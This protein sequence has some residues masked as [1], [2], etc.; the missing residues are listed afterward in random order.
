MANK[1][2]AKDPQD[3]TVLVTG[4]A[5]FIGSHTAVELLK[6]GYSVVVCDDL[7]NSSARALDRVRTIV[8]L[9]LI[10]I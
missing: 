6:Q 1:G 9:S 8:G 10:H 2:L 3:I 7:S 4:G 5:G